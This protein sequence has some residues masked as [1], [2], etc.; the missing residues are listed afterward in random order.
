MPLPIRPSRY[1]LPRCIEVLGSRKSGH[2]S[3]PNRV[4]PDVS[5]EL[6]P[7]SQFL[8][9]LLMLQGVEEPLWA[10]VGFAFLQASRISLDGWW[11]RLRARVL[12]RVGS[13]GW[14]CKR[15]GGGQTD[16]RGDGCGP[17]GGEGGEVR[18]EATETSLRASPALRSFFHRSSSQ[19]HVPTG[20]LFFI[21]DTTATPTDDDDLPVQFKT[22][23]RSTENSQHDHKKIVCVF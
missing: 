23:S 3:Q 17:T 10:L 20:R 11:S 9:K 14:W 22:S 19:P 7:R 5:C 13:C 6:H 15:S 18:W 12:V 2:S 8:L 16:Q 4:K 1:V 21:P